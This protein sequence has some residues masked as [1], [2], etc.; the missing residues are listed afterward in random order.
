MRVA[1]GLTGVAA[2]FWAST[3]LPVFRASTPA[4]EI[5]SRI[6]AGDRFKPGMIDGLLASIDRSPKLP[7]VSHVVVR[8]EALLRVRGTEEAMVRSGSDK[9]DLGIIVS[10]KKVRHSLTLNPADSFLWLM[11]YSLS[12]TLNGFDVRNIDYLDQS[13]VNGPLEGWIALRRNRFALAAFP[14]LSEATQQKAEIEFAAMV[15]SGLVEQAVI[16]FTSVG[17]EQRDRLL[18]SL[19]RADVISREQFAKRLARDGVK[20]NVPGI[21]IEERFGR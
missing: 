21:V 18:V 2:V 6:L 16:N 5:A 4:R 9:A 1:F 19:E 7:L 14:M 12:S 8:A 3:V 11:L 17:W 13:Y 20:V 10:E 15:D